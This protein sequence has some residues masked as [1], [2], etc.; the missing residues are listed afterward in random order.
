MKNKGKPL[1]HLK[2]GDLGRVV[3]IHGGHHGNPHHRHH[4]MH[5]LHRRLNALGIRKGQI[6][7]VTS[8]QPLMGPITISIG[9]CQVTL[10]RGMAHKILVEEI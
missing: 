1:A 8:K 9:N 3:Y 2:I 10:G 7:R 6:I 4:G 5:G